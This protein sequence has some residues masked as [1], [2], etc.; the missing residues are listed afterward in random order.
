MSYQSSLLGTEV[1]AL[2]RGANVNNICELKRQG[3]SISRIS[4]ITGFDRKTIRKYLRETGTPVYGPRAPRRSILDPFQSFIEG[5]LKAGVWNGVVLH[6]LLREQGY[7]GGYTAVKRYLRPLRQEANRVAVRRFETPPGHQGQVDWGHL[8]DTTARDGARK[9][10]STF[11]LT[12]GNSRAMFAD[13]TTDQ[14]LP[15]LLA[16]HERAF[17]ELGGVPQEIL[18]DNMKTVV[19][20]TLTLGTDDRGEIRWNPGFLDFARYWGFTPR[21][22]RP[23]RPQ[24]KGKV[25]AGVKYVRRNFLCGREADSLE[26]LSGQLRVWLAEVANARTHGTTHRIV[27]EAWAQEKAHLQPIGARPPYPFLQEETRRVSEDAFVAFRTNLYAA[28]WQAAGKEVC[29]RLVGEQVHLLRDSQTLATHP[30]CA[31]R[32]QRIEDKALH[33]GMPFVGARSGGKTMI[34]IV[35]DKAGPSV[36]QRSLDVYAEAAGCDRTERA[37]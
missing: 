12:L 11:V 26:G 31:G 32:H 24:T 1:A 30:L 23:Y 37:A 10:I 18:Y 6:G 8:G 19:V 4:E 16:M 17:H 22:C 29:V 21:L 33:A 5:K 9:S 3:L 15:T 20:R 35:A 13:L 2:L 25:E 27:S 7:K 28:P 36:E 14:K 34:S